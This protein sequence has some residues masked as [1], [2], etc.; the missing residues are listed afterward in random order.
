MIQYLT[1]HV[2]TFEKFFFNVIRKP[3]KFCLPY[4]N[5]Y[6]IVKHAHFPANELP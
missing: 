1:Y 4:T 3:D 5:F 6:S 2:H